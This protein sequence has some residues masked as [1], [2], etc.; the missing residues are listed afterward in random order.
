MVDDSDGE[1][2]PRLPSTFI[3]VFYD[4][5]GSGFVGVGLVRGTRAH[6]GRMEIEPPA[7]LVEQAFVDDAR[8]LYEWMATRPDRWVVWGRIA[9]IVGAAMLTLMMEGERDRD[10]R[11]SAELREQADGLARRARTV[12]ASSTEILGRSCVSLR[13][14]DEEDPFLVIAFT[15]AV[16][17]D[18]LWDW[19]RWQT[20]RF[21]GWR[22]FWEEEGS[23][24]LRNLLIGSMMEEERRAKAAGV[25][26][27]GPRPLR[28][29]RGGRGPGIVGPDGRKD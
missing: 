8:E 9:P 26:S 19:I 11:C 4:G 27:S 17:R 12:T 3:P 6:G 2:A 1:R 29:W 7:W 22:G 18:R 16:E 28:L 15:Q 25:S 10:L 14:G 23:A 24:A 5:T 21:R 13:R 20:H